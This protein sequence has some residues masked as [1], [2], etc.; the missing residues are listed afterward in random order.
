MVIRDNGKGFLP[1][2]VIQDAGHGN[3]LSTMQERARIMGG[4]LQIES[5]PGQGAV[6]RL[7]VPICQ[8]SSDRQD[9]V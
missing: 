7:Q 2:Q 5:S 1:E 3:G 6:I 8:I 4:T 9:P